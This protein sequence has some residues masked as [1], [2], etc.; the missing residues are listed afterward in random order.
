MTRFFDPASL[1]D[2]QKSPD[3][4]Q[5]DFWILIRVHMLRT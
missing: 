5:I 3:S 4:V 2:G 1:K